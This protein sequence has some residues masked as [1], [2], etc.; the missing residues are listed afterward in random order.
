MCFSQDA[1]CGCG[2]IDFVRQRQLQTL[3][4]A[5]LLVALPLAANA[6]DKAQLPYSMV[7]GF[8]ELFKSLEHL[9]LIIPS[10]MINSTNSE[11][12]PPAIEFK[13]N[14]SD[15]WQTFSPDENSV[16][17]FPYQPGWAGLNLI[18]NQPKGTLQL[19]IGFS[20]R[21]L[22]STSMPYQDLMGLVPQFDEALAALASLQGQ[23]PQKIKGLTIQLSEGSGAAVHLLAKKGR[24][25]LKSSSAGVVIIRY[26]DALWQ[27]NP[28]VEFDE[29]PVGIVPLR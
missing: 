19:I 5:M 24:Q 4:L 17:E 15:G 9:E 20:A 26:S 6:Q 28:P 21:R 22:N 25:T 10:M 13:I 18:S 7:N 27:E 3:L 8:L 16:M 1:H 14:P 12:S 23:Q 29:L 2:T 11:I